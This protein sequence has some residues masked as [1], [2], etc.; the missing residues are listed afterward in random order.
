M[1]RPSGAAL[2][3]LML[4][5]GVLAGAAHAQDTAQAEDLFNQGRA[6]MKAGNFERAC[7]LFAQSLE[8][9]KAPVTQLNLAKCYESLGKVASAWG[10]YVE[11]GQTVDDADLKRLAEEG[12]TALAPRVPRLEVRINGADAGARVEVDGKRWAVGAATAIDPGKHAVVVTAAGKQPWSGEGVTTEGKTTVVEVPALVAGVELA[13]SPDEPEPP[14]EPVATPRRFESSLSIG[15]GVAAGTFQLRSEME[16]RPGP[17]FELDLALLW[18]PS[19]HF[20]VRIVP[21]LALHQQPPCDLGPCSPRVKIDMKQGGV[22]LL[23]SFTYGSSSASFTL[24]GGAAL[25]LFSAT[26]SIDGAPGSVE[27][28]IGFDVRFGAALFL[29]AR[30]NLYVDLG[31]SIALTKIDP[32]LQLLDQSHGGW[33]VF[34]LRLGYLWRL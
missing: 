24:Y 27:Q 19:P 6:E 15:A 13:P 7:A 17:S 4:V 20:I 30:N 26:W 10:I 28:R 5:L 2:V 12:A 34:A 1:S 29:G 33:L 23:P 25:S 21:F 3:G 32:E 8:F 22:A 16:P 14:A 18:R 31:G 9:D 11:V